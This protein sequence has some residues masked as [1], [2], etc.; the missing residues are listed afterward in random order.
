MA[1][2]AFNDRRSKAAVIVRLLQSKGSPLALGGL[3]EESQVALTEA[4]GFMGPVDRATLT[5]VVDEFTRELDQLA[6]TSPGGVRG[7]LKALDGTLSES[8]AARVA[9]EAAKSDPNHAWAQV[10]EL[11]IEQLIPIA[12]GESPQVSALLLSK[13]PVTKAAE[14]LSGL[15]GDLARHLALMTSRLDE[16]PKEA[17]DRIAHALAADYCS[18]PEPVFTSRAAARVGEMLNSTASG[19]RGEVLDGLDQDDPVFARAVRRELFTFAN[20]PERIEALDIPK[21]IRTLDSV[22]LAKAIG[23]AQSMDQ[24]MQEAATFVLDNMSSRLADQV[25]D[26]IDTLGKV[27]TSEGEAAQAL[28]ISG[29]KDQIAAGEVTQKVA[30]EDEDEAA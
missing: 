9:E 21:V 8:V 24:E 15:P 19:R 1:A 3:P 17:M 25:R 5:Q 4:M 18:A 2:T 29:I 30:D 7:A 6:L 10:T 12:Q 14:L 26:E 23:L 13:L 27:T 20:I 16:V 28:L 22:Q 11:P